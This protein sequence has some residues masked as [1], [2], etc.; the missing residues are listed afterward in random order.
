ML[1]YQRVYIDVCV[2][3]YMHKVYMYILDLKNGVDPMIF[4]LKSMLHI[5]VSFDNYTFHL[6]SQ[7]KGMLGNQ[8]WYALKQ[9][10]THQNIVR[11]QMPR[12][13]GIVIYST[14][15]KISRV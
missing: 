10:K 2:C 1:N 4:L 3:M 5:R 15:V 9:R 8:K 11:A 12:N 13:R 6:H 14:A 7:C